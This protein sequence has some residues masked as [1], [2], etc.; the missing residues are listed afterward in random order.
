[1]Y[2]IQAQ[3]APL[4]L[5][6]YLTV[7]LSLT[8]LYYLEKNM[9]FVTVVRK[10][11]TGDKLLLVRDFNAW[12]RKDVEKLPGVI[13]CHGI[14]NSEL[15]LAFCAESELV[16]INTI[17]RHKDSHKATWMH[18]RPR[19]WHLVDFVIN[20]QKRQECCN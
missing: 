2:C 16:V 9:S 7:S 15:L 17:F 10:V 5:I 13:G 4:L 14:G 6:Q 8:V 12:V 18:P 19:Y 3:N 1:M 20:R 11:P